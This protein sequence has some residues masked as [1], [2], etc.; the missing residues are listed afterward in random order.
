MK[1]RKCFWAWLIQMTVSKAEAHKPA[2]RTEV[3]KNLVLIQAS[4]AKEAV[5]K[6]GK[7]GEAESGDCRGTLRLNGKPAITQ[8]LGIADIGLVYDNPGD[9]IEILWQL[10]KC[11]QKTARSL[12]TDKNLKKDLRK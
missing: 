7:L 3:W 2:V 12:V 6:A 1:Q 4:D 11:S 8:F 5:E 10:R 9:G